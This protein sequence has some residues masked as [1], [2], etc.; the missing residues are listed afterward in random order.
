M[1]NFLMRAGDWLKGAMLGTLAG[2]VAG[3]GVGWVLAWNRIS[4]YGDLAT[5]WRNCGPH[6]FIPLWMGTVIGFAA[7]L[8]RD[9]FFGHI[10]TAAAGVGAGLLA[11]AAFMHVFGRPYPVSGFAA[12]PNVLPLLLLFCGGLA[13]FL[14]RFT[15][16]RLID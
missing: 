11:P 8:E 2:A 16:D 7:R 10:L 13:A 6:V 12:M 4:L 15:V 9:S 1:M 3:T 5:C 14:W